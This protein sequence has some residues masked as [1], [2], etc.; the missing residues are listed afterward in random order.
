[1]FP[2]PFQSLP[3]CAV[4]SRILWYPLSTPN[5]DMSLTKWQMLSAYKILRIHF[6][7]LCLVL[8][9]VPVLGTVAAGMMACGL[10]AGACANSSKWLE[11]RAFCVLVL[12]EIICAPPLLSVF[13]D[14]GR[15]ERAFL[16]WHWSTWV[17]GT[18][19]HWVSSLIVRHATKLLV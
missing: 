10:N 17:N 14:E 6:F 7:L 9:G 12:T 11:G 19:W 2:S 4:L 8:S 16:I 15:G 13:L 1:M 3:C 5:Q 18:L